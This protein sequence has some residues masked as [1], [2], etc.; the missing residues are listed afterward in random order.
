MFKPFKAPSNNH[1]GF[2]Q[3]DGAE[4]STVKEFIEGVNDCFARLFGYV[5]PATDPAMGSAAGVLAEG[6]DEAHTRI[7][8][9]EEAMTTLQR[10]FDELLASITSPQP[11][12]DEAKNTFA[13]GITAAD[14]DPEGKPA[15]GLTPEPS[16]TGLVPDEAGVKPVE[17]E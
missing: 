1:Q 16:P 15:S 6:V 5:A 10:Q 17:G 9:L 13:P 4:H 7:N 11:P 8:E 14:F 2:G 3:G 12:S